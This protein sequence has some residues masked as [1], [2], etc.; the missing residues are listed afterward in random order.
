M[1]PKRSYVHS[2]RRLPVQVDREPPQAVRRS[3]HESTSAPPDALPGSLPAEQRPFC[4][5]NGLVG[6]AL[7]PLG[8]MAT[9]PVMGYVVGGALSA[10][11]VA[12]LQRQWGRKRCFQLGLVSMLELNDQRSK[13]RSSRACLEPTLPN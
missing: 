7:A 9:L 10:P 8:W 11:L 2:T 12:R 13:S 5:I 6:L 1:H 3:P 4:A